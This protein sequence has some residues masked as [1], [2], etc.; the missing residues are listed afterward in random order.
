LDE[1]V[2]EEVEFPLAEADAVL[3]EAALDAL[4]DEDED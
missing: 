2:R 3:E 1:A 4:E